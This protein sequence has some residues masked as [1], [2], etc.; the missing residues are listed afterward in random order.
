MMLKRWKIIKEKAAKGTANVQVLNLISFANLN[1]LKVD[2]VYHAFM[3]QS[4][5]F[6]TGNYFIFHAPF[7]S[8]SYT[9]RQK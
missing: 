7:R 6:I 1:C 9:I 4:S 2:F 8:A 3:I 5:P